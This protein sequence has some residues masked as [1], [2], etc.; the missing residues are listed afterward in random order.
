[1]YTTQR[2]KAV[3]YTPEN[4]VKLPNAVQLWLISKKLSPLPKS[5]KDTLKSLLNGPINQFR[6]PNEYMSK[7]KGLFMFIRRH[8]YHIFNTNLFQTGVMALYIYW[9]VS[10]TSLVGPEVKV[11]RPQETKLI[12]KMCK[13]KL[14]FTFEIS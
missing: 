2:T 12:V 5:L 14:L 13:Q 9:C 8:W 7:K 10:K 3:Q 4:T 1:M 6:D 11:N